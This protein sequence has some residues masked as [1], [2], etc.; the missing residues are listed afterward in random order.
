M[1]DDPKAN[2]STAKATPATTTDWN[3]GKDSTV[4]GQLS[5][6]LSKDSPLMQQAAT[7]ATQQVNQRGLLNSSLGIEAGQ[8]AVISSALPIAQQDASTN[9]T[10]GQ[11]NANA[12]NNASTTNAQL[13]TQTDQFNAGAKN[14]AQLQQVQ[15]GAAANTQE[16]AG[17]QQKDVLG[18]QQEFQA[19]QSNLDRAQQVA[20][21][22]KSIGAQKALQDAQQAF[23]AAQ[24]GT[25]QD[26]TLE[27]MKLQS[28][29][30]TANLPKTYAASVTAQMQS[31]ASAILADPN[32]DP[33]A[34]KAALDN[35]VNFTNQT[36]SWA[37]KF[38]GADMPGL[39]VPGAPTTAQAAT[40]GAPAAAAQPAPRYGF[41]D[42]NPGSYGN[43]PNA[44]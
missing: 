32:L 25:Q 16:V 23:Q 27:Q 17:Q 11:F 6:I 4:Q 2:T 3:V 26:N 12:K 15:V 42:P 19:A 7:R 38:Y 28:S 41:D 37:S 40:P 35:L 20:L 18:K 31:Q 24:L 44:V 10:A 43:N 8:N 33:P 5:G 1:G 36:L 13:T 39:T 14:Q 22:D 30:N 9:A 29:L 34:K 21:T